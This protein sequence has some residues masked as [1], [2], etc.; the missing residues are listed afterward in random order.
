MDGC[1]LVKGEY[2]VKLTI[3]GKIHVLNGPITVIEN[4]PT[5]CHEE[6]NLGGPTYC[7]NHQPFVVHM[8]ASGSKQTSVSHAT[9]VIL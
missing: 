7:S 5:C 3:P 2:Q 8:L 4:S 9:N 6:L 1:Q